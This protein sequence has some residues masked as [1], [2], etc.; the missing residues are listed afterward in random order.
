MT[1]LLPPARGRAETSTPTPAVPARRVGNAGEHVC[2][3][4][5]TVPPPTNPRIRD[6]RLGSS[7][8]SKRARLLPRPSPSQRPVLGFA[9]VRGAQLP[10]KQKRQQ[11]TLVAEG[12][13]PAGSRLETR[14]LRNTPVPEIA[15]AANPRHAKP[16]RAGSCRS[17]DAAVQTNPRVSL[18]SGTLH[19]RPV[20]YEIHNRFRDS[21]TPTIPSLSWLK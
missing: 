13:C 9:K 2:V 17:S 11:S 6:S 10:N 19:S 4:S 21:H 1:A 7:P 3:C 18:D 12:V 16:D 5:R 8:Q 20:C 14:K 15:A